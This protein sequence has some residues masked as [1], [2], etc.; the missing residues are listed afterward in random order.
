VE[1]F[2]DYI[3]DGLDYL[4]YGFTRSEDIYNVFAD[5][6]MGYTDHIDYFSLRLMDDDQILRKSLKTYLHCV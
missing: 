5:R 1:R 3:Q 6:E 4:T 2:H